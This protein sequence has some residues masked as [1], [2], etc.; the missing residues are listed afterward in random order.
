MDVP[1]R[2]AVL[3]ASGL[4]G[5]ALA[6]ALAQE[7]FPVTAIARR[8]TTA[9]ATSFGADACPCPVVDLDEAALAGLIARHRPDI[10][11]NCLGVLQDGPRGTTRDVHDGFVARLLTAIAAQDRPIL[12]IHLSIP[13][14]EA[15]DE[16]AFSRTKREAERRI[17]GSGCPS[18]VLRPGFVIAP[19]AYGGSALIRALA[20]A[21]VALPEAVGRRPFAV[22]AIED[23]TRTVSSV[24]R[25]W[26]AGEQEWRAVW[27]VVEAPPSEVGA[28]V[29]EF[30]QR[31]GGASP[32]LTLPAP[33]LA[34]GARLGDAAAF[35][36]WLPPVRTTALR[37]MMRGVEGDPRSWMAESGLAPTGLARTLARLPLTVQERWFGRLYLLKPLVIGVLAVFWCA[38]GLIALIP[39]FAPAT[40]ILTAHGIPDSLARTITL[41][42]SLADIAVG[43]AI[44]GRRSCRA[45][46]T[47]G[48]LLSLMYMVGAALLAPDLWTEP[49]GALVKTGP[50]I[51][52]ML[53][54]LATLD[55]R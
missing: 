49:L 9:Q 46:L 47:A 51:V 12:L 33:L 16:T 30:R 40:A 8:F 52:L 17:A 24:A 25:R 43:L 37:E 28:V 36:G 32:R 26:Q 22:T 2:I 7:G 31:F 10:V 19:G 1:A 15:D 20:A 55:E 41:V 44:A 50:A 5:Q 35:L 29:G 45:G 53:V 34:A 42:T 27:D 39:A 18:L 38:S 4:I 13:G 23:I 6:E 11:V 48:I 21:P 14:R 54:A 3:G